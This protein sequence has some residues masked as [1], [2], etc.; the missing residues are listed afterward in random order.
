MTDCCKAIWKEIRYGIGSSS[1][2]WI[3]S[4]TNRMWVKTVRKLH[5]RCTLTGL[6]PLCLGNLCFLSNLAVFQPCDHD[7]TWSSISSA[8]QL[9][10]PLGGVGWLRLAK[11]FMLY[12]TSV[13]EQDMRPEISTVLEGFLRDS[14]HYTDYRLC[15]AVLRRG[16]QRGSYMFE[17]PVDGNFYELLADN[18]W[19]FVCQWTI[20]DAFPRCPAIR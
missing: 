20:G 4:S 10:Q 18:L 19:T 11:M 6:L 15:L 9:L 13:S 7:N 17:L 2:A 12:E 5:T 3:N 16:T 1:E 14:L 8:H